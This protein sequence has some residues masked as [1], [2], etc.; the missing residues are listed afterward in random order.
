MEIG[1][2]SQKRLAR[3]EERCDAKENREVEIYKVRH[4]T[5]QAKLQLVEVKVLKAASAVARQIDALPPP[6]FA[7]AA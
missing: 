6:E 2:E 1:F 4:A 3:Q 7:A 5:A